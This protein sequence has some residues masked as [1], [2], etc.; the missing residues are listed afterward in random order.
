MVSLRSGRYCVFIAAICF[1]FSSCTRYHLAAVAKTRISDRD[2]AFVGVRVFDGIDVR[3]DQTV[4]LHGSEV[5]RIAPMA[6][7]QLPDHVN[8]IDGKDLTL[9]PG[10]IDMHTHPGMTGGMPWVRSAMDT[11]ATLEAFLYSGVTSIFVAQAGAGYQ[12]LKRQITSGIILGPR[13][14]CAFGGLTAP[15]GHPIPII[16]A[17][18]PVLPRFLIERMV[19]TM[20]NPREAELITQRIIEKSH[21]SYIKIFYDALPEASP[22][23]DFDSLKTAIGQARGLGVLSAVHISSS[24]DMVDAVKAGAGIIM[25]APAKDVLNSKQLAYLSAKKVPFVTT[26]RAWAGPP[27][28]A[29]GD[30]TKFT[31][32]VA[33]S[34]ML[35]SARQRPDNWGPQWIRDLESR[36]PIYAQVSIQNTISLIDAGVPFFPGTDC[37]LPGVI[38]GAS[39]HDEIHDLVE[40]G[41]EPLQVLRAATAEAGRFLDPSGHLGRIAEGNAADLILLRGDPT[42]DIDS[43]EEIE[44]VFVRGVP[45]IRYPAH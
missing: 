31:R 17:L 40:A 23:L 7:V 12:K 18:V 42:K 2:Y 34:R 14:Y 39:L 24:E 28:L 43:L 22:H 37:G 15:G 38:P 44:E 5:Q 45:L 25:H 13:M 29:G 20:S 35:V 27:S 16:E 33:D 36:L 26:H 30:V 10:L 9:M 41:L 32:E 3:D 8:I 1:V 11:L 21:A 4:L 19:P 6:V